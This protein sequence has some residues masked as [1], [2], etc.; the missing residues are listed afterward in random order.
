VYA[1]ICSKPVFAHGSTISIAVCVIGGAAHAAVDELKRTFAWNLAHGR[2]T[3][4]RMQTEKFE[5]PF[6]TS[7]DETSERDC[8]VMAK[9]RGCPRQGYTVITPM[10]E[11]RARLLAQQ[12]Q[13]TSSDVAFTATGPAGRRLGG[14]MPASTASSRPRA[15]LQ[16][17]GPRPPPLADANATWRPLAACPLGVAAGPARGTSR[18]TAAAGAVSFAR[19]DSQRA[20]VGPRHAA[21]AVRAARL[22]RFE[23]P[24]SARAGGGADLSSTHAVLGDL[25]SAAAAIQRPPPSSRAVLGGAR[26]QTSA[27]LGGARAQPCAAEP[28]RPF[29]PPR[30]VP[31][32]LE[33]AERALKQVELIRVLD[34]RGAWQLTDA[35]LDTGNE[36][37]TCVDEAFA[38]SLGLHVPNSPATGGHGGDSVTLRGIVPGAQAQAT[39]INVQLEVRGVAF[40]PM[41]VA[42]TRLDTHRPVLLG[43]DVLSELFSAGFHIGS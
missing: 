36:L 42:L 4:V 39:V 23:S 14:K 15:S 26:A 27:V 41:R 32:P 25:S 29:D 31:T 12:Q 28:L 37:L 2:L 16:A 6:W 11:E 34:G 33:P 43:M 40:G 3:C 1:I 9:N 8:R 5:N 22:A 30:Y 20:P 38:I 21:E 17:P 19:V 7:C 24:A 10:A 35:L 18:P 13:G